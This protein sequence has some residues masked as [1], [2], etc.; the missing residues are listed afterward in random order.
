M[1]TIILKEYLKK[2]WFWLI[3][4]GCFTFSFIRVCINDEIIEKNGK[5]VTVNVEFYKH[6]RNDIM[7][8]GF[9][10]VDNKRYKCFYKNKV[11]LGS[12]FKIKYN[13]KNPAV[14]R[15]VEE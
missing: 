3:V 2:N 12:T 1:Y 13:P 4:I 5:V 14:W 10:Y 8:G 7:S 15:C 6:T 9:F 11:P